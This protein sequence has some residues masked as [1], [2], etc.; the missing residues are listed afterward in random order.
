M[1]GHAIELQE[2]LKL[3][4]KLKAENQSLREQI[5]ELRAE[6]MKMEDICEESD[7]MY[8]EIYHENK[9]LKQRVNDL[10]NS[11]NTINDELKRI[12]NKYEVNDLESFMDH[13]EYIMERADIKVIQ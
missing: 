9:F 2:A 1:N 12:K 6:N 8:G 13:Y 10:E 5:I 4:E 7:V 11:Y 3:I